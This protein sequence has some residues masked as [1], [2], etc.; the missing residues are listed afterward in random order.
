M[1]NDDTSPFEAATA[2]EEAPEVREMAG[3]SMLLG[4]GRGDVA[5]Y[6]N[7]EG[8]SARDLRSCPGIYCVSN[9]ASSMSCYA[10]AKHGKQ[11]M[12]AIIAQHAKAA[13][14]EG[15]T[16]EGK[17]GKSRQQPQECELCGVWFGTGGSLRDHME[18]VHPTR[19]GGSHALEMD[20][21]DKLLLDRTTWPSPS[22]SPSRGDLSIYDPPDGY[23]WGTRCSTVLL[24][25]RGSGRLVER[26]HGTGH[27]ASKSSL[28]C[29]DLPATFARTPD[30]HVPGKGAAWRPGVWRVIHKPR[31]AVRARP[32][33]SS[34][35][36]TVKRC[37]QDIYGV[38][39]CEDGMKGW[40]A[41]DDGS[42]FMLIDGVGLGLGTLLE[43][44]TPLSSWR[45]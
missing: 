14:V 26:T 38:A 28:R 37:G 1:G 3:H 40:L 33:L 10:K 30:L 12:G 25:R 19:P 16:K 24:L 17:A 9:D 7:R 32:S 13:G 18:R 20:L 39:L 31:V 8:A 2:L 43:P 27:D 29:F 6:C 5:V 22:F 36:V 34:P 44:V 15:S 45:L 42:G 4:N 23:G 41:L 21:L 35:I 11:V